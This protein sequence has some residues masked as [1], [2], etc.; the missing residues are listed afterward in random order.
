[1]STY[2]LIGPFTQVVTMANLPKKGAIEDEA[3]SVIKDAGILV[4]GNRIE[5]IGDFEKLYQSTKSLQ[6]NHT[7]LDSS[8][9][10]LPGFVDAHTH[11][12]FGGTRAKD[13]AMRNGG[14][15]YGVYCPGDDREFKQVYEL[16]QQKRVQ[17]I[18][19]AD[20]REDSQTCMWLR[21]V[22]NEIGQRIV[23]N[24]E[25]MLGDSVGAPPKHLSGD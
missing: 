18:G 11:I 17:A 14:K 6:P 22:I 3:L 10:A 5:A 20:Y 16:Q 21:T 7:K 8:Y 12:C 1:M 15:T 13:Y 24:R 19:P 4:K 9:I 2:Q 23:E 25:R